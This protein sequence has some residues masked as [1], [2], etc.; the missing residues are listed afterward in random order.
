MA[1]VWTDPDYRMAD[2]KAEVLLLAGLDYTTERM[3]VYVA[4]R[5]P[6]P[7]LVQ[8]AA[9]LNLK[10]VYLP[11]GSLSPATLKRIRVMHILSGRDKR[12]IAEEYIW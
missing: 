12:K 11:L 6:R 10:I 3:V 2:S 4:A 1:D 9:R 5:P 8:L 7:I